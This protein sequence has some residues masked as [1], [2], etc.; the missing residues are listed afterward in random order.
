MLKQSKGLIL[1]AYLGSLEHSNQGVHINGKLKFFYSNVLENVNIY[2]HYFAKFQIL[3]NLKI[4]GR[5]E[6]HINPNFRTLTD[7][8]SN[9]PIDL[10]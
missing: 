2:F 10:H 4:K 1:D 3:R 7:N 5:P 8:I 9:C 6:L